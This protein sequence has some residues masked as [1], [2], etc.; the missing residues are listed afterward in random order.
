[1]TVTRNDCCDC[2]VPSYPCVH[3]CTDY[4][5]EICDKCGDESLLYELD[6]KVLCSECVLKSLPQCEDMHSCCSDCDTS[7]GDAD[8]YL[9]MGEWYC[10]DC[11]FENLHTT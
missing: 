3:C 6:G 11:L 4:N 8:L 9:Y 7:S 1:M 2:A 5:V 10:E